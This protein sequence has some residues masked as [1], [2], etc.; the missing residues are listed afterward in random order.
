MFDEVAAEGSEA[1]FE[2]IALAP[3]LTPMPMRVKWTLNRVETRY[4]WYQLYGNWNWEPVTRRTRVATGE[5]QL[6]SDP[7]AAV[8]ACRLGPL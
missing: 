8:A 4:Q 6:G 2:L 1:G 3:D 5:A 7:H